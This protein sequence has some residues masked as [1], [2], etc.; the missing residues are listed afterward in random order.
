MG[1]E[2]RLSARFVIAF[3]TKL[4]GVFALGAALALSPS[5]AADPAPVPAPEPPADPAPPPSVLGLFGLPNVSPA[6]GLNV[7]LGQNPVPSTPGSSA[8]VVAPDLSAFND[9]YLLPQNTS[10]AA[11]GQ[12]TET[13]GL[14]Q[15]ESTS[16][17]LDYL[18]LLYGM[19]QDGDLK[20]A[21]LGQIPQD[22]L[23]EPLPGTAPAPGINIPPGLGQAPPDPTPPVSPAGSQG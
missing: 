23:G 20:G 5:A 14:D 7:L 15:L 21:L 9:Q 18:K 6:D 12:G 17:R 13:P 11:P 19:Y 1:I 10:P 22:Q 8:T 2:K 3:T 4:A 16:G